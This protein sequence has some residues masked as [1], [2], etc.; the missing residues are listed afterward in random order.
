MH[1]YMGSADKFRK[2]DGWASGS[3]VK[4]GGLGLAVR[5]WPIGHPGPYGLTL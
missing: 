1:S 2:S 4:A 5:E 3:T